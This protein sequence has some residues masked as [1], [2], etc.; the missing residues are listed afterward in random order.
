MKAKGCIHGVVEWRRARAFFY[1]RLRRKLA[2]YSL[3]DHISTETGLQ[4]PKISSLLKVWY[5]RSLNRQASAGRPVSAWRQYASGQSGASASPTQVNT[6]PADGSADDVKWADDRKIL[7]WMSDS[8][9]EIDDEISRLRE[10]K[11]IDEIVNR[12]RED[13]NAAL[14]GILRAVDEM[15]PRDKL[16]LKEALN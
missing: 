3:R 2:E 15:D 7:N 12:S 4:A 5:L 11:I 10:N 13:R 1:Y 8:A 14:K 9:S 16:R 6:S